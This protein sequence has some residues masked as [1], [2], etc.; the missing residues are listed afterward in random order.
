MHGLVES[1]EAFEKREDLGAF[2]YR[3]SPFTRHDLPIHKYLK[4]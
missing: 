1:R 2:P 4:Q 3:I